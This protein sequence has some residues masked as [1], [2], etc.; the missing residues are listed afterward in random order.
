MHRE[1]LDQ[2]TAQVKAGETPQFGAN[3]VY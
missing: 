3:L 1:K 2:W